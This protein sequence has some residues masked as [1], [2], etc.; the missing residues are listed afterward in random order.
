MPHDQISVTKMRPLRRMDDVA[1]HTRHMNLAQLKAEKW[2]LALLLSKAIESHNDLAICVN[3]KKIS[4]LNLRILR[5][6]A[7]MVKT[8]TSRRPAAF[9]VRRSAAPLKG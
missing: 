6:E 9:R 5:F 2:R 3:A 8:S 4:S 7:R 1:P